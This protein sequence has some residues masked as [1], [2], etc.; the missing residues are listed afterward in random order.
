MK[1]NLFLTIVF[2]ALFFSSPNLPNTVATEKPKILELKGELRAHDP[3]MIKEGDTYYVFT[4]GGD[5]RRGHGFIPIKSSK[6]MITWEQYG[7][8]FEEMPAWTFEEI[9]G[10]R[11]IWAP[12]ISYFNGAYH[13]Y[14]SV[15]TFGK[16]NSA[17][18]LATNTTLDTSSA[19]YKWID[20]GMVLRSTTGVT[21]WNAIDPNIIIEEDGKCW[22]S[23]GSFWGG[24]KMKRIDPLTGM[25][26]LQDT[27]LYSIAARPRLGEHQ[28]PPVV[29]AIEAPFVFKHGDFYYLFA[30]FDFCCRGKNSTYNVRVGRS[31]NVNGPY[32]DKDGKN[33]MDGGGTVVITTTEGSRWVGP[34]HCAVVRDG[35]TDYL[36]FHAY[37]GES[38]RFR[39]ELKISTIAWEGGWP[40]AATLP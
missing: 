5:I 1:M 36:V 19:D 32:I 38:E 23:W 11:G 40:R 39:S 22:I 29:G 15:S 26:S 4:T 30:S 7:N 25:L 35:N 12:D 17:I 9:P 27:T 37:D 6:D 16:N 18:G 2:S 8:V 10:T 34:G 21:G 33:M 24:L 31:K 28:T 3:V 20:H 14:Y 13:I